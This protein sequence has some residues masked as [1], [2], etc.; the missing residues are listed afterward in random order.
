MTR[1]TLTDP[2]AVVARRG[3]AWFIDLVLC[4]LAAA[5]PALL[6]ADA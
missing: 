3:G 2:T 1:R 4:G 5:V 6:L